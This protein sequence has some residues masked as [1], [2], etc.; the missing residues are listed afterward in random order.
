MRKELPKMERAY[1]CK[2]TFARN[3]EGILFWCG[4]NLDELSKICGTPSLIYDERQIK[5]N[6]LWYNEIIEN[7]NFS[8]IVSAAL[9][10]TGHIS[11]VKTLRLVGAFC[12]V[13]TEE[14]FLLAVEAG[15]EASQI[16]VNG[17]GWSDGLLEL[18]CT[19]QPY[20]VNV[21]NIEDGYKLNKIALKESV[22][23]PISF[24]I[25]PQIEQKFATSTEKL[26]T[27]V[28][29]DFFDEI[30]KLEKM[31][32]LDLVGFSVHALHRCA[33]INEISRVVE[34]I[35]VMCSKA[36]NRGLN[37]K[38]INIGG[39]LDFRSNLENTDVTP[40]NI[41]KIINENF[42]NFP[43][44]IT[45]IFE[46][47][48]FLIGDAAIMLTQVRVRKQRKGKDWIIVDAGTNIL[49]PLP[50][51]QFKVHEIHSNGLACTLFDI[52]DGICSPTSVIAQDCSLSEQLEQGDFLAIS[53]VGAYALALGEN[54]GYEFPTVS[55][56][57]ENGKLFNTL[58][59][60]EARRNFFRAWGVNRD[61]S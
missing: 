1:N 14:E 53:N 32:N 49:I 43:K 55:I 11:I 13:M 38:Y 40:K 56:I 22:T 18:I 36:I 8:G 30:T 61:F 17:L 25:V 45:V 58:S 54:W 10:A 60:A 50:T 59:R 42:A 23:I 39:G 20:M 33:D 57:D 31:S 15:Y 24:R 6:V 12:E 28:N 41:A 27:I 5:N 35:V 21:D 34:S 26:G 37:I 44:D 19:H 2:T 9:K 48:R 51:A 4:Q 16:I 47:G 29:Q 52:G 3:P 46:P 7:I